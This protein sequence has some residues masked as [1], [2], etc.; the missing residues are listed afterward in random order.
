PL[1]YT[2]SLHDALPISVLPAA[3]PAPDLHRLRVGGAD[4]C[5]RVA[6]LL[7]HSHRRIFRPA[8]RNRHGSLDFRLAVFRPGIAAAV[9]R[10]LALDRKSTRLNSSHVSI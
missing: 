3:A 8:I 10:G 1:S 9:S 2:L 5:Q 6:G 7:H 4:H